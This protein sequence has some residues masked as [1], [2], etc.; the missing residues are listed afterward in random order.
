MLPTTFVIPAEP[1]K[2]NYLIAIPVAVFLLGVV[3]T[4]SGRRSEESSRIPSPSATSGPAK[5]DVAEFEAK[6]E[7]D[8]AYARVWALPR[9]DL[10]VFLS[11]LSN[12]LI[13][14][15]SPAQ[16][17]NRVRELALEDAA[18]TLA[19]IHV[20]TGS[21][22]PLFVDELKAHLGKTRQGLWSKSHDYTALACIIDSDNPAYLRERI[23]AMRATGFRYER[24]EVPKQYWLVNEKAAREHLCML[25]PSDPDCV[26]KETA[27]RVFHTKTG[28]FAAVSKALLEHGVAIAAS[29]DDRALA[30]YL[31]SPGVIRLDSGTE[32]VVVES[33]GILS[34]TVKFRKRGELT[35]YWSMREA[36]ER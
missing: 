8:K 33:G 30:R 14:S 32:V 27:P 28:Y 31:V 20:R 22:P 7:A 13:L 4:F 35:E 3:I 24:P 17:T 5:T 9:A 16:I 19:A 26:A 21:L 23:L 2:S 36:L 6:L 29:G 1:K 10:N 11:A 18:D 12:R 15:T 25:S 34:G